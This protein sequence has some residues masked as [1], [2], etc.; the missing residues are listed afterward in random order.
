MRLSIS[1]AELR[2]RQTTFFERLQAKGAECA[3][4]FS[5]TDIFYLTGFHFHPTERPIG[6]FIDPEQKSHLFVPALEHEHAQSFAAIDYVHSY[7]EYPGLRHPMEYLKDVLVD[8]ALAG[9][10]VGYDSDGYGSAMGYTGPALSEILAAKTF[11]SLQGLVEEMRYV[12]SPAEIELIKESCRWGNLAHRLLQKYSKAGLSEIEI[13]S[14]ATTEATIAMI[15]TLGPDYK[16]HGS[17]ANAFFRGQVGEMSA[18]PHAVTQ[19]LVLKRGDNLVTAALCDVWGYKSE[20]ERTMFVEEVSTEQE[21]YFQLMVE[22]QEIAFAHIKPGKTVSEVDKAVRQFFKEN[23]VQHLTQHHTGHSI[24]LLDHEAPFFDLGDET[25]MEPG[26]VFTVEPGI[27]LRGLGGFRHSD[28]VLVTEE[29]MESL[30][31]YPRDLASL[32]CF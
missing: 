23:N 17:P 1:Q 21:K 32:I 18:I 8:A 31:Y 22:A 2:E 20:L 24:G 10:A 16:P 30:T 7:P 13:T 28:T 14:K 5:V 26:M 19:N 27:Y 4:L 29:G 25:I 15:E 9:K 3:V 6:F 12:K 11:I